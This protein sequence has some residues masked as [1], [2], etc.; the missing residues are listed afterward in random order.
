MTEGAK[1]AIRKRGDRNW[2][3]KRMQFQKDRGNVSS[4]NGYVNS[5]TKAASLQ[6]ALD[7]NNGREST[8]RTNNIG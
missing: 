3:M 6:D 1:H 5:Q 8:S 7:S 2:D 4:E